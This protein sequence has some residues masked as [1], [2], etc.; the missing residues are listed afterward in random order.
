MNSTK[1]SNFDQW[2]PFPMLGLSVPVPSVTKQNNKENGDGV[3]NRDR[4]KTR[5]VPIVVLRI[6]SYELLKSSG[7]VCP[8]QSFLHPKVFSHD[9][10]IR[11]EEA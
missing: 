4:R 10:G 11:E 3:G 8:K 6:S 5:D 1:P 9:T 7:E 2:I